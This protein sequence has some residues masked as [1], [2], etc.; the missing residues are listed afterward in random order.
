MR[1]GGEK[2]RA[3]ANPMRDCDP[4]VLRPSLTHQRSQGER[5]E[6]VGEVREE[7]TGRRETRVQGVD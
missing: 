3:S 5:R 6:R 1:R 2:R 7:R 4:L